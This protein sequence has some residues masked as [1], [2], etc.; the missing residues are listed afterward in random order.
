MLNSAQRRTRTLIRQSLADEQLSP[1]LSARIEAMDATAPTNHPTEEHRQRRPLILMAATTG[2]VIGVLTISQLL[3]TPAE[4]PATSTSGAAETAL[5]IPGAYGTVWPPLRGA[6]Q[7]L[8]EGQWPASL[9]L[10][11]P[12]TVT[13][14]LTNRATTSL[15]GSSFWMIVLTDQDGRIVAPL[16]DETMTI[17]RNVVLRPGESDVTAADTVPVQNACE[18]PEKLLPGIYRATAIVSLGNLQAAS[19]PVDIRVEN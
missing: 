2:L 15:S 12:T 18:R 1:G 3:W 8:V 4:N 10:S 7:L 17:K 6:P 9:S 13:L 5:P 16:A 11:S 19:E 14:Q